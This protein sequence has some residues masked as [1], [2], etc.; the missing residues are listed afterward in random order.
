MT[1]VIAGAGLAGASVALALREARYPGNVVLVGEEVHLPYERPPLSKDVL[2][3]RKPP[4]DAMLQA[5]PHFDAQR[6]QLRLGTRVVRIA[7]EAKAIVLDSGERIAYDALVLATGLRPRPAIAS[8]LGERLYQLRTIDDALRLQLEL[9]RGRRALVVG[10]GLLGLELTA[11]ARQMG[12]EVMVVE[13]HPSLLF[14]SVAPVVG[15]MVTALHR[16]HG[17]R[18]RTCI[19]PIAF[20]VHEQTVVA[21]LSDGER[22]EVD[23]VVSATGSIVNTELAEA[24][25]LEVDDGIIVDGFGRT[26]DPSIYA[27]GDVA[28]H[29]N[30]LLGRTIRVESW[31]NALKQSAAVAKVIVGARVPYA[32][33]PWFWSDQFDMNL[34]ITG[35]SSEWDRVIV[36]GD[37]ASE[38]FTVFYLQ[39]ERLQAANMVNNGRDV[40]LATEWI[41]KRTPLDVEKLGQAAVPLAQSVINASVPAG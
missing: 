41:A 30:P 11:T 22:L 27:V 8:A 12:C 29:F 21:T 14:Q 17:V 37:V 4:E 25:G 7:R 15:E 32:E 16:R 38:R 40:R 18:I 24:C 1:V 26:S 9:R 3:G 23:F 36:R 13:R 10:G 6:I 5:R 19:T 35:Y 20:D 31:H 28:R 34:Q 33:V 2:S 39:G